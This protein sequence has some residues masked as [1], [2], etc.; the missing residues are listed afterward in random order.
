MAADAAAGVRWGRMVKEHSPRN[1]RGGT[2]TA[3]QKPAR[4]DNPPD[5]DWPRIAFDAA[6]TL[7]IVVDGGGI[8]RSCNAA[9]EAWWENCDATA[10]GRPFDAVASEAGLASAA[11][12]A[13]RALAGE[14]RRFNALA[15]RTRAGVRMVEAAFVPIED[16]GGAVGGFVAQIMDITDRERTAPRAA[17]AYSSP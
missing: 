10:V 15:L 14:A 6:P 4:A 13:G 12:H 5:R 3:A 9:C 8:V 17:A 11:A 7:L 1:E 2:T 16:H